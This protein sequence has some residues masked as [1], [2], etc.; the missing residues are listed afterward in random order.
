[1]PSLSASAMQIPTNA[2]SSYQTETQS[3]FDYQSYCGSA[4]SFGKAY[5]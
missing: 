3:L 4:T 2:G 1:M 5:Q